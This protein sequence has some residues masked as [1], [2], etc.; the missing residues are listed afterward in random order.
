MKRKL[1]QTH[2]AR[3][4]KR[5]CALT[6]SVFALFTFASF[7]Y[8]YTVKCT[9]ECRFE[10]GSELVSGCLNIVRVSC[11]LYQF[12]VLRYTPIIIFSLSI[13]IFLLLLLLVVKKWREKLY[14]KPTRVTFNDDEKWWWFCACIFLYIYYVQC[15]S[16]CYSFD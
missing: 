12:Y 4:I 3:S 15:F 5:V 13:D 11:A 16:L 1:Q 10:H 9:V 8:R 7:A 6:W 2:I 14:R